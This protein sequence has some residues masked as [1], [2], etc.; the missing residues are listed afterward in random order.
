MKINPPELNTA[1]IDL[2]MK[3][4]VSMCCYINVNVS[5]IRPCM[6]PVMVV[7]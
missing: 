5:H 7:R 4:K 6:L 2:K 1:I 3:K